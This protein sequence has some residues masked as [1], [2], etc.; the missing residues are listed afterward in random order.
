MNQQ[1]HRRETIIL[2]AKTPGGRLRARDLGDKTFSGHR[3]LRLSNPGALEYRVRRC[4]THPRLSAQ[5]QAGPKALGTTIC[6]A[7]AGDPGFTLLAR[8]KAEFVIPPI[9]EGLPIA[10]V[11][12]AAAGKMPK[13]DGSPGQI[14]RR[15]RRG[16]PDRRADRARD[17]NTCRISPGGDRCRARSRAGGVTGTAKLKIAAINKSLGA[18]GNPLTATPIFPS[19]VML[20]VLPSKP[21]LDPCPSRRLAASAIV[22]G[23]PERWCRNPGKRVCFAASGAA[24]NGRAPHPPY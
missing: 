13:P 10:I 17:A 8:G 5:Q 7:Q 18:R 15:D 9:D 24:R 23:S 20:C 1:R 21:C 16:R 22:R 12:A 4:D 14:F 11:K 2:L 6:A 3:T 19:R